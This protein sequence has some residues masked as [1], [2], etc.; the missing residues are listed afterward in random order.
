MQPAKDCEERDIWRRV[1][2]SAWTRHMVVKNG[3]SG[4]PTLHT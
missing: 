3:T 2:E 1:N 4:N